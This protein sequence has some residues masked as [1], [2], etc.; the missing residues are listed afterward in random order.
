MRNGTGSE[1]VGGRLVRAGVV[2]L[3]RRV[4]RP[5]GPAGSAA[6]QFRGRYLIRLS[7]LLAAMSALV[8][9][10]A[11]SAFAAPGPDPHPTATPSSDS[12]GPDPHP[13]A[14]S[15]QAA[16]DPAPP[17]APASPTSPTAGRS[18]AVAPSS[19]AA[20][21]AAPKIE[22]RTIR[23]VHDLGDAAPPRTTRDPGRHGLLKAAALAAATSSTG[24]GMLLGGLALLTLALAS[25][26]LLLLVARGE[27]W[28]AR[29]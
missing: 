21:A 3:L 17:P 29:T 20:R 2:E 26:G 1:R 25:S 23:K 19:V 4:R 6:A 5:V 13:T 16:P 27:R 24:G 7:A 8:A 9:V 22:S 10:S 12:L 11:G 15:G 14:T 18:V 28:E